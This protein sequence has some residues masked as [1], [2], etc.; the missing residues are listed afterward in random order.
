MKRW[1]PALIAAGVLLAL[2][3]GFVVWINT[4]AARRWAETLRRSKAVEVTLDEDVERPPL[5]GEALPGNAWDDYAKAPLEVRKA[6]VS[7]DGL[8]VLAAFV[9]GHR[10]ADMATLREAVRRLGPATEVLRQGSRRSTARRVGI[11]E[12][13]SIAREALWARARLAAD[14]GNG[15]EAFALYADL[16]RV[17]QDF[18]ILDK[19]SRVVFD[20]AVGLAI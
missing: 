1:K 6:A 11:V 2:L 8:R 18:A 17:G 4:V 12:A 9:K 3:T 16:L 13:S 10:P 20:M 5:R 7:S 19:K 15:R 14:D